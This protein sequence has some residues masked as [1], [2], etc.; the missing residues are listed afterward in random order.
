MNKV[1]GIYKIT[2]PSE[3]IYIGQS[4]DIKERWKAHKKTKVN[5]NYITLLKKYGVKNHI[6]EIIEE[7][8]IEDLNC[9]ERYW[10]DF[11][12]VLSEKG[13]NSLLQECGEQRRI[14][15]EET[16]LLLS[17]INTGKIHTKESKEKM[18]LKCKGIKKTEREKLNVSKRMIG[19]TIHFMVRS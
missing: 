10:Q 19:K 4:I 5:R 13:L 14:V 15:S 11:Y 12:E 16:K 3:R 8:N 1:S 7:C 2:S 17:R 9:R 18:S 6:F